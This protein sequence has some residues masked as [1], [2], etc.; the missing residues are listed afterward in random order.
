[1]L[2]QRL[3]RQTEADPFTIYRALRMLNPSP[4]MF[5]LDF[6]AWPASAGSRCA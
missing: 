6:R 4:Y 1:V 2:S 5:F 3:S